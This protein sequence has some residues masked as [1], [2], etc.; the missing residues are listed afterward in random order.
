[1]RHLTLAA[2]GLV[3]AAC[4]TPSP[5]PSGKAAAGTAAEAAPAYLKAASGCAVL[6][7]GSIGSQFADANITATWDKVNAAITTE[8]HDRLVQQR[9]KVVKTLVPT[10]RTQKL[11]E[12]LMARLSEHRC[13][14]L[15]QVSHQVDEDAGGRYFRFDVTLLRLVPRDDLP[16]T[17][18]S[19]GVR[20]VG[21]YRREYRYPRTQQSFDDF[22][23]GSFAETVLADLTRSGTLAPLR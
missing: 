13:N 2:L 12:L 16:A 23:T 7:G 4:S 10:Q 14:R 9:Y 5:A 8:L 3:L 17:A 20:T 19:V 18:G 11:D 21:E 22:Y 1:M 6:A 15:L